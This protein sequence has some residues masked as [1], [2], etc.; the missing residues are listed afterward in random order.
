MSGRT[1]LGTKVKKFPE[2]R[3]D[4]PRNQRR[5]EFPKERKD[6]TKEKRS[7]DLPEERKDIT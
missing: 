6:I 4:V 1:Y 2:E 5:E 7:E 3:K